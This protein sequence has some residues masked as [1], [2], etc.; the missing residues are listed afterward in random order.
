VQL[1]PRSGAVLSQRGRTPARCQ[2]AG[3]RPPAA[4]DWPTRSACCAHQRRG[5][6][7]AAA[8]AAA[9]R[10]S[11]G[12]ASG[13]S[14][15]AGAA[16][17]PT[18]SGSG[19][20]ASDGSGARLRRHDPSGEPGLGARMPAAAHGGGRPGHSCKCECTAIQR[21][22]GFLEPNTEAATACAKEAP[23][24]RRRSIR[25]SPT[26]GS[27]ALSNAQLPVTQECDQ[28]ATAPAGSW[29]GARRAARAPVIE[30]AELRELRV[31]GLRRRRGR[32]R[33]G[34]VY[35][36]R[37]RGR[38]RLRRRAARRRRRAAAGAAGPRLLVRE[39]GPA[40]GRQGRYPILVIR[41]GPRVH[42]SAGHIRSPA[43]EGTRAGAWPR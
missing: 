28:T 10:C 2:P 22:H 20:S 39:A 4:Q 16:C 15:A 11:E 9:P 18:S 31:L 43:H 3:S 21:Q 27:Q 24:W 34:D 36:R 19:S 26:G 41:R 32:G 42:A 33:R 12:D 35:R 37:V 25:P 8:A 13:A 5:S 6:L 7:P 38:R 29:H 40:C 1:G 30:R 14:C 17:P 23:S